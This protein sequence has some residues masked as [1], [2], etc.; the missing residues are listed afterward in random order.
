M[1]RLLSLVPVAV[2]VAAVLAACDGA[3]TAPP[4]D[5]DPD[6]FFAGE[7]CDDNNAS[8]SPRAAEVC[9]GIDNDCDELID[10]ADDDVNPNLFRPFYEDADGDG[11]GDAG[12][13]V[14]QCEAPKG[15]VENDQ[16]CDDSD[17]RTAPGVGERCDQVDND[18]DPETPDAGI[19]F[20]AAGGNWRQFTDQFLAAT[21]EAPVTINLDEDGTLYVCEGTWF[22]GFRIRR[23]V[24]VVGAGAETTI[25]DGGGIS[26]GLWID[27]AVQVSIADITLRNGADPVNVQEVGASLHCE[28]PAVVTGTGVVVEGGP[29]ATYGGALS[30]MDGCEMALAASNVG[31]GRA[32]NGGLVYVGGG[33]LTLENSS[34]LG[35]E[36]TTRGGGIALG[37][38]HADADA[39]ALSELVCDECLIDTN[40]TSTGG[41]GAAY[42]GANSTF[43]MTG[44]VLSNHTAVGRGGAI[45]IDTNENGGAQ[46][47]LTDT[48]LS[49]NFDT[50]G[51]EA[52]DVYIPALDAAFLFDEEATTVTCDETDGCVEP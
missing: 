28:D 37:P 30:V 14:E 8:I 27:R 21:E 11:F 38:L 6:G 1:R 3:T 49:E 43:T 22:G 41:G 52:N 4:V 46:V 7:H 34:L 45:L 39:E 2:S 18:C 16:D 10:D 19:A 17:E 29:N 9:D 48:S 33:T 51:T 36:A 23:D 35:G 42:V 44:G 24:D 12:S 20:R 25:L 32:V 40:R 5:N 31:A 26:P 13:M 50:D 15:Y 47:S